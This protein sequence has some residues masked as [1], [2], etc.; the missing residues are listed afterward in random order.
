MLDNKLDM[1]FI[2]YLCYISSSK[3]WYWAWTWVD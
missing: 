2:M 1:S 3:V